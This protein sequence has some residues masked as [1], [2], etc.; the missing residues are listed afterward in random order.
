MY[1]FEMS[2][3]ILV[4]YCKKL[5]FTHFNFKYLA[6]PMINFWW[7]FGKKEAGL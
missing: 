7:L 5:Q 4:I 2:V 6:L 1:Y 3:N